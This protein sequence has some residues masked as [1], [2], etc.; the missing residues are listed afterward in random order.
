VPADGSGGSEGKACENADDGDDS[1]EFDQGEGSPASLS[2]G[3]P[4]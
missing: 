4:C 1:E 2:L 3:K